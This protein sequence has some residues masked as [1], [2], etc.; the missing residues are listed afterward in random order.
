MV[1]A[2]LAIPALALAAS[3][4]R[5]IAVTITPVFVRLRTIKAEYA[6]ERQIARSRALRAQATDDLLACERCRTCPFAQTCVS[7]PLTAL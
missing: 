1:E 6:L 5:T 7:R 4:A 2:E 3:Q